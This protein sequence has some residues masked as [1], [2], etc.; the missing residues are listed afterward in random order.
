[1]PEPRSIPRAGWSARRRLSVLASTLALL[2]VDGCA[3][4]PEAAP[5]DPGPPLAA[6]IVV[7]AGH[8]L[9][10]IPRT[11]YST[12][13]EWIWDANGIWDAKRKAFN[14]DIVELTRELGVGLIRFP[15]GIHADFYRW[16]DG[17]GPIDSRRPR[18]CRAGRAR[19]T[20]S[21]PKRR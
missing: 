8:D 1:V 5:P 19:F 12:N 16:R 7:D 6:R 13:V 14:P 10:T 20:T 21:G 17:I 2:G 9:R 18:A 3:P 15:A 11:L 4:P